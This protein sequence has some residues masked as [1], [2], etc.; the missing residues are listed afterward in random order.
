MHK[1]RWK[2]KPTSDFTG[3]LPTKLPGSAN[4][5][6]LRGFSRCAATCQRSYSSGIH[7]LLVMYLGLT[8]GGA[9]TNA[10]Q[11]VFVYG[12][13]IDHAYPRVSEA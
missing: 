13:E 11:A 6:L 9:L 4:M 3:L 10:V 7:K 12:K 5:H 2:P 8:P 1:L